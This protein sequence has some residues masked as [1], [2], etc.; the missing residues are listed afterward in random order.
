MI[1]IENVGKRKRKN[2]G[3]RKKRQWKNAIGKGASRKKE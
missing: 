3:N 1:E 2:A